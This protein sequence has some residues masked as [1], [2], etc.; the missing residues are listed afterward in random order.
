MAAPSLVLD[1]SM[2]YGTPNSGSI[3]IDGTSYILE[4]INISRGNSE[5]MSRNG[6]GKPNRQRFT[7]DVPELTATLQLAT[8]STA[9]PEFGKTFTL[10]V[11]AAYGSETWIVL[12]QDFEATNSEGE[13]RTAPLKAKKAL[14]PSDITTVA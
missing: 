3:T 6:I 11:D 4:N 2:P 7:A 13:I 10:T 12:P 8:S 5:A 1:G 9:Y 14:N